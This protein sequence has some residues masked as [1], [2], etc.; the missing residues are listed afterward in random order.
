MHLKDSDGCASVAFSRSPRGPTGDGSLAQGLPQ[1]YPGNS[2]LTRAALKSRD[3]GISASMAR[4]SPR[5][6]GPCRLSPL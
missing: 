6:G 1:V 4:K 3:F 5:I 2:V